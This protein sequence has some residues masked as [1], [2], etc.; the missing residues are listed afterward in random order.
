MKLFAIR[1][2]NADMVIVTANDREEALKKAGLTAHT[3]SDVSQQLRQM[4][5]N[6]DHADLVLEG[7]G[8]QRYDIRE[9]DHLL[10]TLRISQMGQFSLGDLDMPSYMAI[11]EWG[12]PIM[13]AAD[14]EV[15]KRWP[16]P[17]D[18]EDHR[19]EHDSL[20]TDAYSREKTRLML[21]PEAE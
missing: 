20:H 12:Y 19:A 2:E 15:A 18:L 5:V 16:E 11:Y 10:L 9:L 4:G 7:I 6:R 17:R 8:P 14:D 1:L 3:L 13:S 21:P